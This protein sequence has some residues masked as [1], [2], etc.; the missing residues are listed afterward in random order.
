M[1]PFNF[2]AYT[3]LSEMPVHQRHFDLGDNPVAMG[4]LIVF[5]LC[6]FLCFFWP[7]FNR[8]TSTLFG[9]L[10]Y[11]V[12]MIMIGIQ[13]PMLRKIKLTPIVPLWEFAPPPSP[14]MTPPGMT[15]GMTPP[16]MTP[17]Q[18]SGPQAPGPQAPIQ[19]YD[20]NNPYQYRGNEPVYSNTGYSYPQQGQLAEFM[21]K[22]KTNQF[23]TF[24]RWAGEHQYFLLG[25][26]LISMGNAQI[27]FWLCPEKS[28]ILE[29]IRMMDGREFYTMRTFLKNG[30]FSNTGI[31]VED[32]RLPSYP[33]DYQ[34][35]F[36]EDTHPRKISEEQ[37][38]ERIEF[39]A[40]Q[41][42]EGLY[43]LKTRLG[44]DWAP[45]ETGIFEKVWPQYEPGLTAAQS[46]YNAYQN[47]DIPKLHQGIIDASHYGANQEVDNIT[48][49]SCWFLR[50]PWWY[51]TRQYYMLNKT[52][53]QQYNSG[54]LDF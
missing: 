27:S 23:Y 36:R 54:K 11:P 28:S 45:Y 12:I 3:L 35:Y 50:A 51:L 52:L 4:F 14:N 31:N 19:D 44:I 15:P 26:F 13:I 30:K 9:L 5:L 34:V 8:L 17:P 37:A 53:E 7:F 48:G 6:M 16:T 49:Y 38:W 39:I 40:Q 46:I 42:E 10:W 24:L 20:Y 22:R 43:F 1:F 21:R 33:K 29:Y 32:A 47:R 2:S 25:H 41:H 18:A